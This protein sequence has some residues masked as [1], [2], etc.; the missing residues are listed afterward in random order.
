MPFG[1]RA[2]EILV[3]VG[4]SM[5]TPNSRM[6]QTR[7]YSDVGPQGLKNIK[8]LS[9]F[10]VFLTSPSMRKPTPILPSWVFSQWNPNTVGMVDAYKT[11][12][13]LGS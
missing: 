7:V 6:R 9:K 2:S 3:S 8:N 11:T 13:R 1:I 4:M 12:G 10:E 5:Y